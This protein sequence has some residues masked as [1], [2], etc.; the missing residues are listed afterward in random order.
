[1]T[2]RNEQD[3][4][5][6]QDETKA[7]EALPEQEAE[8]TE[9]TEVDA[10][11][12]NGPQDETPA[13]PEKGK[14]TPIRVA[15]AVAA[16]AAIWSVH[17]YVKA[18][19]QGPEVAF[20]TA[21]NIETIDAAIA[22]AGLHGIVVPLTKGDG[23]ID[24][25]YAGA[26]ECMHCQ[27]FA[28][29]AFEHYPADSQFP[30]MDLDTLVEKAERKG[31]DLAYMPL[32]QTNIGIVLAAG[33]QCLAESSSLTA[34]A[35]VKAAYAHQETVREQ[36]NE[37]MELMKSG[38]SRADVEKLFKKA[39]GDLSETLAPGETLD[40]KCYGEVVQS[41]PKALQAFSEHFGRHGTPNFF[42]E[43]RSGE[44]S[45]FSG[46]GGVAPMLRQVAD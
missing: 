36:G 40:L 19:I 27:D 6:V 26:P 39:L 21:E 16:V 13:M 10:E 5:S 35:R 44:V 3:P 1:M 15:I 25:L 14:V 23:K 18:K 29:G 30:P 7:P 8:A 38:A 37:A 11:I 12:T 22:A 24:I 45:V 9:D 46:A 4:E 33:E 43:N 2:D 28:S 41:H 17:G 20:E 31:L 32:A 42:F 34:P